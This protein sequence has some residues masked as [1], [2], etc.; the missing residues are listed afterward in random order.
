MSPYQSFDMQC[1]TPAGHSRTTVLRFSL[2]ICCSTCNFRRFTA[3]CFASDKIYPKKFLNFAMS[4]F[5]VSALLFMLY[6]R[7]SLRPFTF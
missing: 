6:L 3:S 2:P 1:E 7:R 5:A 4:P